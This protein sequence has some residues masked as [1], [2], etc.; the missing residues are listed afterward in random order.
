MILTYYWNRVHYYTNTNYG[1]FKL[2][3]FQYSRFSDSPIF[4]LTS[5]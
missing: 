3:H 5:Y 4:P 2:L 1:Y